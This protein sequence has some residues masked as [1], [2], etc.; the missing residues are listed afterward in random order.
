M[1]TNYQKIHGIEGI[2]IYLSFHKKENDAVNILDKIVDEELF[3]SEIRSSIPF[4]LKEGYL[5]K[6]EFQDKSLDLLYRMLDDSDSKVRFKA[7]FFTLRSR[8]RDEYSDYI[9]YVKK[10]KRHLDRI[11]SE[12]DRPSWDARLIEVLVRFLEKFWDV[13]PE[14]TID[15]LEKITDERIENYSVYQP[16]LA[17]ES[18]RILAGLFQYP[19]L[20]EENKKRCLNILDKYAMAGWPEALQLLSAMERPD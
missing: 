1:P 3:S 7:T 20:S 19:A 6:D 17:E 14:K 9:K 13:L 11:A 4:I 12:M 15:Y 18:V 16:V 5:F 2:L 10:I 8:E